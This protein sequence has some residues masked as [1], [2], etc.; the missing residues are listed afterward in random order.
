VGVLPGVGST[1]VMVVPGEGVVVL[2]VVV[3]GVV[4]L[5]VVAPGVVVLG[6]VVLGVV[7]LGVV[8]VPGAGVT[9]TISAPP[10]G[11]SVG[12]A[13]PPRG[14]P[15]SRGV[16]TP[17][18]R[19]AVPTPPAPEGSSVVAVPPAGS[20]AGVGGAVAVLGVSLPLTFCTSVAAEPVVAGA[21]YGVV[22]DGVVAGVV[23]VVVVVV[24]RSGFSQ[25]AANNPPAASPITVTITDPIRLMIVL[26][27]PQAI[28]RRLP[29]W[30]RKP[31]CLHPS[32]EGASRW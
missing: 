1:G 29:S 8:V 2:G 23:S 22:V 30:R 16:A 4:V 6:V 21:V 19:V 20:A 28:A 13:P 14:M 11:A 7:V 5:G 15:P 32:H 10:P 9:G 24:V 17:P 25:P 26:S 12:A 3:P 31:A 18:S 27:L